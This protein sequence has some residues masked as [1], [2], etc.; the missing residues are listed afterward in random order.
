M[1]RLPHI[2]GSR[3]SST[4]GTFVE[5]QLNKH[6]ELQRVSST[7]CYIFSE[8]TRHVISLQS[9]RMRYLKEKIFSVYWKYILSDK[10]NL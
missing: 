2:N 1:A 5:L 3:P 8:S 7:K 10:Y 9:F 4:T 6:L